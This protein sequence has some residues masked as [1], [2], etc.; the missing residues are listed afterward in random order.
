MLVTDD[1]EVG[2]GVE[3]GGVPYRG[4]L[5]LGMGY[6]LAVKEGDTL[7]AP[8]VL[9]KEDDLPKDSPV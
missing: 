3:S 2:S 7:P 8:V 4:L 5:L 9:V 6:W 1:F